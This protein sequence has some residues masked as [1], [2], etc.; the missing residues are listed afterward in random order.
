MEHAPGKNLSDIWSDMG[1]E[2]KI[3]TMED[4]V[5]IQQKLLSVRFSA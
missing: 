2:Q 5:N 3:Q 1:L 4:V